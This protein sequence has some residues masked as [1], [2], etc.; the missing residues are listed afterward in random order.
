[1]TA[2]KRHLCVSGAH[3][4]NNIDYIRVHH[5][6]GGRAEHGYSS[7]ECTLYKIDPCEQRFELPRDPM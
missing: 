1:M 5:L 7:W 3:R 4:I 2:E 6:I